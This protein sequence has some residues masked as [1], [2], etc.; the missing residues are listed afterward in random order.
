MDE[1]KIH[2]VGRIDQIIRD[3]FIANP[4]EIIILAKNM[5]PL[6]IEKEIFSKDHREGKPIRDIFRMLDA[7]KSLHLLHHCKVVRKAKNRNWYLEQI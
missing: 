1:K 6:F 4:G 5:M 3:Y 2:L 7:E